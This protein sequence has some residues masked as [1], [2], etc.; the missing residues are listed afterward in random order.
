M[1]AGEDF[2]QREERDGIVTLT[3]S[4]P[5]TLNRFSSTEQF[6]ELAGHVRRAN[7]DP[8]A[9]VLV[10]TGQGR[11]F[12]AGGDLRQMARREM[13]SAGSVSQVQA[14]YRDT[15]HQV[16]L[17]LSEIEIPIIAAVNGPAYG[18][19]CDLACFCDIRIAARSARFSVSFARLGIV[20]GDGGAWMLPR[21]VGRSKAMEL[22]FT[23]DPIDADEALRIGLVSDVV[24]D[25]ELRARADGLARRIARHPAQAMRMHKRLLRDAEQHTLPTHLDVVAAFQAIAHVSEEHLQAVRDALGSLDE[26][27]RPGP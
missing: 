20:A 17:A 9:R 25:D 22:A 10:I 5:D 6:L 12:C 15:V 4:H 27:R 19:G 26:G 16:P 7:A 11:A 18:A 21:L 2:V 23:A 3:L 8:A 14:R 13:F 24:P 1:A